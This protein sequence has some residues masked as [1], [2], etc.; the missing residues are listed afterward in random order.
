MNKADLK[1]LLQILSNSSD[2][3][4]LRLK[5]KIEKEVKPI[6]VSSRK[7]KGR[8]L[9]QTVCEKFSEITNI[10]WGYDNFEIQPRQMGG[11][12][13]DVILTG[14]AKD[15]LPFDVEA[16]NTEKVS[17][18][19]FID[20][21]KSNTTEGRDWLVVHKKNGNDPVAVLDLDRFLYYFS[22]W[23]IDKQSKIV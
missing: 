12:G 11:S 8:G 16:K 7:A 4:S 9:Q 20:Q 22:F 1:S 10:P 15:L 23:L 3:E 18:Y 21:A 19:D 17:L 2:P 5:K 13:T 6:S 14:K